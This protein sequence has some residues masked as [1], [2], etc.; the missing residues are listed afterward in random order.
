MC[1]NF[2]RANFMICKYMLVFVKS[3]GPVVYLIYFNTYGAVAE[4]L[5]A[6]AGY[7]FKKEQPMVR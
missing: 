7:S 1:R 5:G 4:F 6:M 2:G 3:K